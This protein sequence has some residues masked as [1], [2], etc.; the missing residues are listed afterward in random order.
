MKTVRV[1]FLPKD[2]VV[3]DADDSLVATVVSVRLHADSRPQYVVEWFD[4]ADLKSVT[5]DEFRL[6]EAGERK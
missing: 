5:V 4:C 2:K 3:F 6:S 1:K